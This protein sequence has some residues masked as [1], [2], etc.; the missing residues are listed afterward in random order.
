MKIVFEIEL[1]NLPVIILVFSAPLYSSW[2]CLR[3]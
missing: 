3:F 1:L 2:P